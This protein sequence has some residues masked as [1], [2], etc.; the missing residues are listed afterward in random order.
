MSDT[1]NQPSLS[2]WFQVEQEIANLLLDRL[3]AQQISPEHASQIAKLVVKAIPH[4][5]T[6]QQMLEIIP[7]LDDEFTEL[8]SVVY[9][10]LKDY[11]QEHQKQVVGQVE[12]LLKN[13]NFDQAFQLINQY[14]QRKL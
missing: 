1:Q 5:I 2:L 10:H 11:E 9:K 4:K 8:A 7:K 3:E 12:E 13:Q 6:D 14:F